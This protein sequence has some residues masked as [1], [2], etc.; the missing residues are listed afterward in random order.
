MLSL[1][2]EQI[3]I[4]F[5]PGTH[6]DGGGFDFSACSEEEQNRLLEQGI[7]SEKSMILYNLSYTY[8]DMTQISQEEL[9]FIFPNTELIANLENLGVSKERIDDLISK[10]STYREIIKDALSKKY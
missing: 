5:A 9:D 2:Q 8:E 4:I 10:G 6:L 3:D 7:D 1:A